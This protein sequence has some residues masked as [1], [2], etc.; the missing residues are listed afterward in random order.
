MTRLIRLVLVVGV[1]LSACT[2]VQAGPPVP[3]PEASDVAVTTTT[4]PVSTTSPDETSDTTE[5]VRCEA[6]LCLVYHIDPS[7]TWADGEPV[8][9]ADFAHTVDVHRDP[10][11]P[12]IGAGYSLIETVE[13]VDEQTIRLE[14]AEGYGPW[15]T[16]FT[17]VFRSGDP[18]TSLQ[19]LDTSGPFTFLEWAEGE[20]LT[21]V[22]D[23]TWWSEND[24]ISGDTAGDIARVRFVFIDTLE[25]MVDALEAGEVDVIS[26]RPDEEMMER[27]RAME[28]VQIGLAPGP[29]WEHIDFHHDDP[30][31]SSHWARL[32]IAHAIDREEILDRTVRILDPGASTLDNTIWM[33]NTVNYEPH[34]AVDHDPEI[35]E[36]LLVDNG[37]TRGGD[38]IHVCD[39]ARMSFVWAT[40]SDDPARREIFDAVRED[41]AAIGVE[42]R[43]A[44]RS[45][46]AFVT[47]DFLF[48][49]PDSWQMVNFSWRAWPDPVQSHS[50]YLCGEAGEL[51][52]N[53]YCSEAVAS[54]IRSADS[55]VDPVERAAVYNEADR[56]YLD[57]LAL[58]P[59][60]QK[61]DLMAWRT[62]ISGPE[63][64]YT[65]SSDMWNIASWTGPASITVALPQ[66][67]L[68]IDP[69]STSVDSANVV[70]GTL[71][72]GAYGMTPSHD[73]V[74]VLV[75]SVDVIEGRP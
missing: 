3:R 23:L 59:L 43:P 14:M 55:I 38:G 74:P 12:G 46:S 62:G 24:P 8:T 15:Q 27:L 31:F 44:F 2:P 33:S 18:A 34:F 30:I 25:E 58:I 17:R 11:Q 29:F 52:V 54:L 69:R 56:I 10:A 41:L 66:E 71:I 45:P 67:P 16:L 39:G 4:V 48:G 73:Y 22:R 20:P 36:Q 75:D 19:E 64:N 50:T 53:R 60:Y 7:A 72:Y 35:A 5:A 40:T 65:T 68:D 13:V 49:G 6:A 47:R 32:A 42:I 61:P 9:A 1:T 37:C 21:L 57:D 26:A 70:L 63:P 28:D 51:N